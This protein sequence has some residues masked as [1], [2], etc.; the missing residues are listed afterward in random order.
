MIDFWLEH[1]NR[2]GFRVPPSVVSV[3]WNSPG[4]A[5]VQGGIYWQV[6]EA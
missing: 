6:E 3:N 1:R 4:S 2:S 5:N